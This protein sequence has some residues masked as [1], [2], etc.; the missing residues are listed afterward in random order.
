M[1]SMLVA[2]GHAVEE[3]G[4]DIV[5]ECFVI[6]EE[7]AEKAEVA[8]PAALAAAVDFKEGDGVVAVDLVARGVE[9]SAFC[10]VA[11][12]CLEGGVVAKAEFTDV[13]RVC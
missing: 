6:E 3:E 5:I 1:A 12:K 9:K 13:D 4:I 8:A 10:A 11:G 7:F 2:G